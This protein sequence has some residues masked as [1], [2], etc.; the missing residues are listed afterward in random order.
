MDYSTLSKDTL[1]S[2][3]HDQQDIIDNMKKRTI[4]QGLHLTEYIDYRNTNKYLYYKGVCVYLGDDS[5]RQPNKK[6]IM[7]IINGI[8]RQ[9]F[10]GSGWNIW[11]KDDILYSIGNTTRE[12]CVY[13]IDKDILI[14]KS[15][16]CRSGLNN[17]AYIK[18]MIQSLF[19]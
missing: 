18:N 16:K 1:I 9:L 4:K 7:C 10:R 11:I 14:S 13:I 5:P 19:M 17:E 12:P 8:P 6:K 2:I 3:I 15:W